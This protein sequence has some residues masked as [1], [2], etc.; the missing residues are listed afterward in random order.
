MDSL[1][2]RPND[3]Q[4]NDETQQSGDD[5]LRV[6]ATEE[7][8]AKLDKEA[9]RALMF[10]VLSLLAV[11][12]PRLLFSF[13]TFVCSK[14]HPREQEKCNF[15]ETWPIFTEYTALHGIIQPASF[16][17]FSDQFWTAWK[18]RLN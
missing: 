5:E 9:M 15:T 8:I 4:I 1:N 11:Y 6:H 16:L 12:V 17:W 2:N 7:A 10:S 3:P 18:N 14:L 13:S